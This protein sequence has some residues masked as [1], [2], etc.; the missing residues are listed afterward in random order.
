MNIQEAYKKLDLA[1]GLGKDRVDSQYFSLKNELESK[2]LVTQND[3]LK[4][5]YTKR[6]EEVEY[7]YS[8]LLDHFENNSSDKEALLANV[9]PPSPSLPVPIPSAPVSLNP[10]PTFTN[11]AFE[12]LPTSKK[13]NKFVIIGVLSLLIVGGISLL[14]FK[15]S[16]FK[17]GN[18]DLFRVIEGEKRV[19]VNNLILR[20]FPDPESSKIEVFPFGTRLTVDENEPSKTD[21]KNVM[22]R[23]VRVMHPVYGWERPDDRFPYPYEG[24]MAI[25]QCGVTWIEDS[26]KTNKLAKILVGNESGRSLSSEYRHAL[27]AYFEAN[28]YLDE[29]FLYG[30]VKTE[31]IQNSL[32]I[33]LG[34]YYNEKDCK[35][36]DK[37]NFIALF[38]SKSGAQTKLLVMS[39]DE[40]GS[41][42][43]LMDKTF[44]D[45]EGKITGFSKIPARD[46]GYFNNWLWYYYSF[47]AVKNAVY[48]Y[49]DNLPFNALTIHNGEAKTWNWYVD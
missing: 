34:Y 20:Q 11:Y 36:D 37:A 42:R 40:N 16:L 13:K 28:N 45:T 30:K 4:E 18:D 10:E 39:M 41:S 31:T 43:V 22:W 46:I 27:V 23:K 1:R 49:G 14:Y 47:S 25:Q 24:W 7:A 12:P 32:S 48:V 19:F 8:A 2:I 35:G 6:L 26:T 33:N 29:W 5:V 38:N 44:N 17:S 3:K 21:D 15:T 9:I